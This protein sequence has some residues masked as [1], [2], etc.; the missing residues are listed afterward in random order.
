MS[1]GNTGNFKK[2]PNVKR[3]AWFSFQNLDLFLSKSAYLE[4][5][6][7]LALLG[8][9]VDFFALRSKNH[10]R[11]Y[12]PS[13]NLIAIPLRTLPMVAASLYVFLLLII[14]P[15]YVLLKRPNFV[16]TEPKFGSSLFGIE[17]KMFPRSLRPVLIMDV[18]STSVEVKTFRDFLNSMWFNSSMAISRRI[19]DGITIATKEM[20]FEL[21]DRFKLK[22]KS[23]YVWRNGVDLKVFRPEKYDKI[24]LKRILDLNDRFVVFYHGAFRFNGGLFETIKSIKLLENKYP[25][26]IFFMLGGGPALESYKE[27]IEQNKINNKVLIHPPV[28]Y[29]QVPRYISI[30]D[31]AIVP[32]PDIPDWRYQSPLKLVE[33]LAMK[34]PVIATDIPA[35]RGLVGDSECCVYLSSV[36][37]EAIANAIAFTYEHRERLFRS[38]ESEKMPSIKEYDWVNVAQAFENYLY[39]LR[40]KNLV[41]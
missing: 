2:A 28:D 10:Y 41:C 24:D 37:P 35:N 16:I 36:N 29:D 5:A 32:L 21:C 40:Q 11:S 14:L 33:Y 23:L 20:R 8:N 22:R 17:L 3:I 13:M 38:T 30:C 9:K 19:F 39:E 34:K 7:N 6:K 27:L 25:D 12:A 15:F 26:I 4:M 31:V 1:A 18:R